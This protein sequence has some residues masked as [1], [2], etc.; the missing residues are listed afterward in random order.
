MSA[1]KLQYASLLVGV[2]LSAALL[3]NTALS[4]YVLYTG[5]FTASMA[6]T[7]GEEVNIRLAASTG[8]P[9]PLA[10]LLRRARGWVSAYYVGGAERENA[11]VAISVTVTGT[12]V[13]STAYVD[14]YIEARETGGAGSPYRCL[15]GNGTAVA[16]GGAPLDLTN[17]TTIEEHLAAMNLSTEE[18]WTI[19]YYV[20]VRAEVAGAVS[21]ETL[22]TVIPY[23]KFDTVTYTY[24]SVVDLGPMSPGSY[25][26]IRGEDHDIKEYTEPEVWLGDR[27]TSSLY[28]D[29]WG[30]FLYIGVQVPQGATVTEA[31]FEM[32][33]RSSSESF[34][35]LTIW[36]VDLDSANTCPTASSYLAQPLTDAS[37]AWTPTAW[38][39]DQWHE[40]P[41]FTS[42]VQEV[43]NR[44]G[45]TSGNNMQ[46]QIRDAEGYTKTA[47]IEIKSDY[48]FL[49]IS[50]IGY[51]ASW[52][53][54][55]PLSVVALPVSL[56][57]A[58]IAAVITTLAVVARE[59]NN[60]KRKKK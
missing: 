12:N 15:E 33:A 4:T 49:Y 22:T 53:P 17:E 37:V 24:G 3:V 10:A 52:Y 19:D 8:R 59:A 56:D 25:G 28:I 51:D 34:P 1:R 29:C 41:D 55:P 18:S 38:V 47:S 26:Y 50:Y 23:T 11:T 43:V 48:E 14:Y 31:R 44:Q 40:T 9:G 27:S 16:V 36:A 7:G 46:F 54:L 35:D 60:R 45:W 57:V 32:R 30:W 39:A 58:A 21:G 20:Y 2:L 5:S 13:A 6:E 42:V